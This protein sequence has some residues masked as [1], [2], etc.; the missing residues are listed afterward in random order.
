MLKE[1]G[2]YMNEQEWNFHG[3]IALP[4]ERQYC[5]KYLPDEKI[6]ADDIDSCGQFVSTMSKILSKILVD[7]VEQSD[8]TK[9]CDPYR[10]LNAREIPDDIAKS[11]FDDFQDLVKKY[12]K[13]GN[14]P[15]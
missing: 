11:L 1:R 13:S 3:H 7:P 10:G 9:K 6:T 8:F 5:D 4:M 14:S 12:E 2:I 15:C